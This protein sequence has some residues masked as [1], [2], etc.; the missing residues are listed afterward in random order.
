MKG[1][2]TLDAASQRTSHVG[3]G[4]QAAIVVLIILN[5]VQLNILSWDGARS[6]CG[7]DSTQGAA[8]APSQPGTGSIRD[9]LAGAGRAA[10]HGGGA[11]PGSSSR[12]GQKRRFALFVIYSWNY[13]VLV[14]SVRSYAAAG[15]GAHL[16]ILDNS[17]DRRIVGDEVVRGLAAE[18]IPT[19]TRLTFSQSQN[20]LASAPALSSPALRGAC[21]Q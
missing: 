10:M 7:T 12:P 5:L 4:V 3:K 11:R 9:L 20:F 14:T 13:E 16:I 2:S 8:A 15:L 19:R 18:V 6:R 21:R 1:P 17:P